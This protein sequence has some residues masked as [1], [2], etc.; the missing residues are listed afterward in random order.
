MEH[1][2]YH[3]LKMD[4]LPWRIPEEATLPADYL[5]DSPAILRR[6]LWRRGYQEDAGARAFLDP[7]QFRLP[8][9]AAYPQLC[10]AVARVLSALE[11]EEQICVW[12][13]YDAD[14]QTATALLVGALRRM[15][16]RATYHIPN[17]LSE[18]RGLSVGG[19]D[20]VARAGCSLLITCDCGTNDADAVA[21]AAA[22]GLD[23][24]IT[25]HHQQ[26][27]AIPSAVA[28]LN[29]SH[30][31]ASDPLCGLPG[32]AMAYLLARALLI[33][34]DRA[35]ETNQDLDLVALGIVAD[36]APATPASRAMLAR[37]LPR[38]WRTRRP[39]L[40]ALLDLVGARSS[41]MDTE[42]ISFRLAPVLNAAGRLADAAEGVE[43]LLAEDEA[44]ARSLALRLQLLNQ[45]R[46][47]LSGDMEAEIGARLGAVGPEQP[48]LIVDGQDWH[49][50]LI[51]LAANALAA[52]YRR[53]AV[54]IARPGDGGPARGSAR[55]HGAID[56][57]DAL[58]SQSHLLI[59]AGGHPGAAGFSLDPAHIDAF[60]LHFLEVIAA[61]RTAQEAPAVVV[62]AVVS[63]DAVDTTDL[64]PSSL[65]GTLQR[66]APFAPGN[67]SPVLASFGLHLAGRRLSTN[68]RHLTLT[69][70][71]SSGRQHE[72]VWWRY[73]PT[74]QPQGRIDVAYTLS[75]DEWRG[76][77]CV[78][79][80]LEAVRPADHGS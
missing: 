71:D 50:G 11:R 20:A 51:G 80:T 39:G 42:A 8:E 61:R 3:S 19:I 62:D 32:V 14:G 67:L 53:P 9:L 52:Q 45:E 7:L 44:R 46:R 23:V 40:R 17:R 65:Y 31:P 28:V 29:S 15:G 25:D 68:G 37:G 59:S 73:D 5:A 64:G 38:L 10:A 72:V 56:I 4:H 55:G 22:R 6:I 54:V 43:L 2:L 48:A 16:A 24:V 78:R 33:R 76:H 60:R 75:K 26:W 47:R 1:R 58:T 36:V 70:A 79:L 74:W 30:L 57:L 12:G 63:W 77:T 35:V 13:D 69:L 21:H 49:P 66:L 41:G 18:A 27:G 34:L